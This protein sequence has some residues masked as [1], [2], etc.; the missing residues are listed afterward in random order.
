MTPLLK[1]I[2]LRV[3][4]VLLAYAAR[5][6]VAAVAAGVATSSPAPSESAQ[7]LRV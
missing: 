4:F 1:R 7:A 6:P 3:A 2:F 5:S